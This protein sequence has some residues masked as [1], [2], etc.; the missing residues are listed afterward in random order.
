MGLWHF[1]E[2]NYEHGTAILDHVSKGLNYDSTA[3]IASGDYGNELIW[4]G[5]FWKSET[6]VYYYRNSN[7]TPLGESETTYEIRDDLFDSANGA[8]SYMLVVGG[9]GS[10]TGCTVTDTLYIRWDQTYD[11]TQN[12][13]G[14]NLSG[15]YEFGPREYSN[16]QYTS[17][18]ATSCTA[19]TIYITAG[20]AYSCTALSHLYVGS[21]DLSELEGISGDFYGY[22]NFDDEVPGERPVMYGLAS[23][24]TVSGNLTVTYGGTANYIHVKAG[25]LTIG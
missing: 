17:G 22:G 18:S 19:S 23:G 8:H 10:A 24:C 14:K 21:T 12:A 16:V 25:E 7:I 11:C 9:G 13:Y 20:Q 2:Y 4:V 5:D 15:Y 3:R 6:V 1:T